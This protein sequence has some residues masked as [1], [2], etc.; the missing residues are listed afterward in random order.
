MKILRDVD[1]DE[2]SLVRRAANRR[3]QLLLKGDDRLDSELR[4]ILDAPWEREGALLDEIRK[5][6]LDDETVERA[7]VAAVRLLKGV[8][9]DL[10]PELIEKLGVELYGR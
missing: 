5:A 9:S 2:I 7:V 1:G 8:E 4:D 6:G 3:R 10:T